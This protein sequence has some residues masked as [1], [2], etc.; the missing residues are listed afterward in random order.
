MP[1]QTE[2]EK[3]RE[4]NVTAE[5][6][7][8]RNLSQLEQRLTETR[9]QSDWYQHKHTAAVKRVDQLKVMTWAVT[10]HSWPASEA[11]SGT[12]SPAVRTLKAR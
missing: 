1:L 3:Y 4:E 2:I 9:E 5:D 12:S 11:V 7:R 6:V 8:H 10:L